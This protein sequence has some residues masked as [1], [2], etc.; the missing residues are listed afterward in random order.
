MDF[1]A[2][3]VKHERIAIGVAD[4]ALLYGVIL[5]SIH[6]PVSDHLSCVFGGVAH[7]HIDSW[8]HGVALIA[9]HINRQGFKQFHLSFGIVAPACHNDRLV[10]VCHTLT[11]LNDHHSRVQHIALGT[12]RNVGALNADRVSAVAKTSRVY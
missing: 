6:H 8:A 12:A 5:V 2:H 4:N 1:F 11:L 9:S 7:N 10:I 3:C